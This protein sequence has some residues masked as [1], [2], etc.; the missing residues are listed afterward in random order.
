MPTTSSGEPQLQL[1]IS[2]AEVVHLQHEN[3]AF[4]QKIAELEAENDALKKQLHDLTD[5]ARKAEYA[6]FRKQMGY[7][8]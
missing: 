6:A 4:K 2:L 7:T 3:A 5:P 1:T 8:P